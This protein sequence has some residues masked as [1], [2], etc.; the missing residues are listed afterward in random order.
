MV[1][2]IRKSLALAI[3]VISVV[4]GLGVVASIFIYSYVFGRHGLG[5]LSIASLPDMLRDALQILV[6][7]VLTLSI[8]AI[9][10]GMTHYG[11]SP[12]ARERE[13]GTANGRALKYTL[14]IAL[15]VFAAFHISGTIMGFEPRPVFS[16]V[17]LMNVVPL[18]GVAYSFFFRAFT[19]TAEMERPAIGMKPVPAFTLAL[20]TVVLSVVQVNQQI[21]KGIKADVYP[22]EK[23]I[24]KGTPYT[25]VWLGESRMV[26]R[27]EKTKRMVVHILK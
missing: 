20:F 26:A 21:D 23:S 12:A 8:V 9:M 1:T 5:Y 14:P 24:C 11:I 2:D 6:F 17:A 7:V 15:F 10:F 13:K 4:S 22:V 27:C 19:N 16:W 3:E 25:V 18:S